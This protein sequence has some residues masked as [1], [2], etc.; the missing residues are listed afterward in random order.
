MSSAR[1]V[2]DSKNQSVNNNYISRNSPCSTNVGRSPNENY[3]NSFMKR[4]TTPRKS[5]DR[6]G[7]PSL[8]GYPTVSIQFN[9]INF[10]I[11]HIQLNFLLNPTDCSKGFCR[12]LWIPAIERLL[13]A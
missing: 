6:C 2:P 8:S 9:F 1:A 10:P 5:A 3:Y 4:S 11:V 13:S 12:L 7:S